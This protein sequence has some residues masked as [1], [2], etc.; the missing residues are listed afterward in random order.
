MKLYQILA[1]KLTGKKAEMT[2]AAFQ[3]QP[4]EKQIYNPIGVKVGSSMQIDS[5][6]TFGKNFFV[7][8][9]A[10]IVT[11]VGS[12]EFH[13]ADYTLVCKPIEGDDITLRLRVAEDKNST[14]G[15]KA[16]VLTLH[17]SLGYDE[18]LH[19]VLKQTDETGKFQIDFDD[20]PSDVFPRC[21]GVHGSYKAT[22]AKVGKDGKTE[23]SGM[24]YWDFS[25]MMTQDGAEVEQ[26]LFVEM[27]AD[28]GWFELWKGNEI[29][30][31]RVEA[32]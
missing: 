29:D 26:Y 28:N 15:Y 25:R 19:G 8:A 32:I 11:K 31:Q 18:G 9:V 21:G 6:D 1:A 27:N 20:K 14:C 24:E 23:N 3:A 10:A 22:T 12:Q 2:Q 17:D 13:M 5:L 16:M 30:P 4:P 7:E